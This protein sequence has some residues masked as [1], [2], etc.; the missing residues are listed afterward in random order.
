MTPEMKQ[1]L[2]EAIPIPNSTWKFH[3]SVPVGMIKRNTKAQR[4]SPLTRLKRKT[5]GVFN[6][7]LA[8][9]IRV[10]P[11]GTGFDAVIGATRAEFALDTHGPKYTIPVEVYP[12]ELSEPEQASMFLDELVHNPP[13][14]DTKHKIGVVTGRDNFLR[15]EKARLALGE[16]KSVGALTHIE[17]EYG[18]AILERVT[19]LARKMYKKNVRLVPGA[20]LRGIALVLTSGGAIRKIWYRRSARELLQ[21]A[22]LRQGRY[23]GK[24]NVF[25]HVAA[26]LVGR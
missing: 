26:V 11:N 8:G 3:P 14:T 2:K 21:K 16:T 24:G 18:P 6:P 23:A 12:N 4:A 20:V 22:Q 25:T 17:A 9:V 7:A 1:I 5:G 13:G 10:V 15:V 19:E